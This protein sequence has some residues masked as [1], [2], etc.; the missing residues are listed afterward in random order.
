MVGKADRRAKDKDVDIDSVNIGKWYKAPSDRIYLVIVYVVLALFMIIVLIPLLFI[1]ASSF[2][3]AQAI[4]AGKVLFWPVDFSLEGYKMIMRTPSITTGFI[5]S[6]FY[7]VVGTC[8][9]LALTML[10]AY[11]LTRKDFKASSPLSIM[12]LVTMF[13]NGGMIPTYLLVKNMGMMDTIWAILLPTAMSAYN[14][15]LTRTYIKSTIPDDLYESASLDGCGDFRY[16]LSFVIPLSKTIIAVMALLYGVAIWNSYFN[17]MMYLT[18]P[19]LQP[20]QLVLRDILILNM[21]VGS[22]NDI[23]KQQEL[24]LFTYLLRYSTIVVSS[25]P[26]MVA[27]PFVQKYFVKGIMIGAIKG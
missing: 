16:F 19:D 1:V 12:L 21:K 9:S 6:V 24:I 2:S 27:Y 4:A 10:M 11:P 17:A 20:L 26:V 18:K 13:F 15:I 5:N 8:I 3:S 23:Q 25:V 7:T 14:V 22:S